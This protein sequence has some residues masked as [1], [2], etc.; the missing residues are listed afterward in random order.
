MKAAALR[1][2]IRF[3]IIRFYPNRKTQSIPVTAAGVIPHVRFPWHYNHA[4]NV[5]YNSETGES[6]KQPYK[7]HNSGV[8]IEKFGD[9]RAYAVYL[10]VFPGFVE[11][12]YF[13]SLTWFLKP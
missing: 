3:L 6:R 1:L 2:I 9:A 8:Y 5:R 4:D 10:N 11:F 12:F 7:P 13:H